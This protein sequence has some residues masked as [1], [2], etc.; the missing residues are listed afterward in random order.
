MTL[1]LLSL[2][3]ARVSH[4][5]CIFEVMRL[6]FGGLTVSLELVSRQFILQQ[7]LKISWLILYVEN[8]YE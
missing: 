3:R 4:Q 6:T 5:N 7:C 2:V 8:I 1:K